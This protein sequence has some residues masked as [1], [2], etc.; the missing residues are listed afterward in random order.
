MGDNAPE[1]PARSGGRGVPIIG[2]AGG[3]GS[4]KSAVSAA[5]ERLGCL[6]SDSDA[7]TR[8]ALSSESVARLLREWWGERVFDADGNVNRAAVA[9][10]VFADDGERK[11]LEAVLHPAAKA[12]RDEVIERAERD[13][14]V[15][16]IVDAPLLFESGLDAT[17][18]VVVFVDAPKAH[19]LARVEQRGWAAGELDRRESAQFA[20]DD[21]RRSSD[22]VVD[23]SGPLEDLASKV[24]HALQA[25]LARYREIRDSG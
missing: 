11:R 23:N 4:G 24:A 1:R 9:R 21:K 3:I 14:A 8:A 2:V 7:A 25:A 20:L 15:A 5:F 13:G 16:V 12:H 22:L 19:R 17:C 10:I 18:D 6:V